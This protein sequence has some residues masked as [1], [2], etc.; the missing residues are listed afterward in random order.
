MNSPLE[1][2]DIDDVKIFLEYL[3]KIVI[4]SILD[5]Q[6]QM[7]HYLYADR[8]VTFSQTEIIKTI[9]KGTTL[10]GNRKRKQCCSSIPSSGAAS[11]PFHVSIKLGGG[12]QKGN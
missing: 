12:K 3:L 5:Q 10:M 6:S 7:F 11:V 4:R 2:D 9:A 8:L 1:F